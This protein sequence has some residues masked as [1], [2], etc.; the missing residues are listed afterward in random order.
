MLGRR[1][2]FER[3]REIHVRSIVRESQ[4]RTARKGERDAAPPPCSEFPRPR[5]YARARARRRRFR[6]WYLHRGGTSDA[7]WSTHVRMM[8]EPRQ[9]SGNSHRAPFL[10]TP[11]PHLCPILLDLRVR[12]SPAV[13]AFGIHADRSPLLTVDKSRGAAAG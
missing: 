1:F 13:R 6:P 9:I 12:I 4:T 11:H 7:R 3:R 8:Y 2:P 10:P 5:D